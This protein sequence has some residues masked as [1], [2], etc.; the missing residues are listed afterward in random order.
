MIYAAA[1]ALSAA[2]LSV[3]LWLR[4]GFELR[5]HVA[6]NTGAERV[7]T[8]F[9]IREDLQGWNQTGE[10]I[11]LSQLK[12]KV[13]VIAE[14]FAIC[15]HCAVR[16]GAELTELVKRYGAD[17]NFHVVCISIDPVN[18]DVARLQDYA[19]ALGADAKNW[20]FVTTRDEQK[21]H[22]YMDQVMK[23]F[24]VKPRTDPVD[25]ESN[26]RFAHDLG[27]AVINK[28]FE[29]IG[30]WPLMDA[31]NSDPEL[32]QKLKSDMHARIDEELKK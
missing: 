8:L 4:R 12:N 25:I 24:S 29:M 15:P 32:Y 19:K 13:W 16:N 30:K 17:P 28:N 27:L 10:E 21:A 5:E 6:V 22:R 14:F 20:W 18:D 9:P 2:I 26:G 1:I 3:S 11:K 23:F 7:T 31:K